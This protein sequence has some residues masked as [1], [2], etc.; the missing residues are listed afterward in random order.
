M[1]ED[2][3]RKN[4]IGCQHG[5]IPLL[6]SFYLRSTGCCDTLLCGAGNSSKIGGE[7]MD[8]TFK[9]DIRCTQTEFDE[10]VKLIQELG[11]AQSSND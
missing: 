10:Y 8:Q 3:N 6:R 5:A 1:A 4:K 2:R 11:Y 7:H 9:P